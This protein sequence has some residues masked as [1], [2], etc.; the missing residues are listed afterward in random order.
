MGRTDDAGETP[1]GL[2]ASPAP[3]AL[4]AHG[5][6]PGPLLQGLLDPPRLDGE[7]W[8]E[9]LLEAVAQATPRLA[10]G[11]REMWRA[12][13]RASRAISRSMPV[14]ETKNPQK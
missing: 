5:V 12:I 1:S 3:E 7:A 13:R 8:D 9:E 6:F 10:S 11:R 14:G 2:A 4:Q